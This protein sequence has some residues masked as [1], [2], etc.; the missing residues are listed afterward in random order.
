MKNANRRRGYAFLELSALAS[1]GLTF[2]LVTMFAFCFFVGISSV[3]V[4][5]GTFTCAVFYVANYRRINRL[6][7]EITQKKEVS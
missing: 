6:T 3:A 1:L 4:L 2:E 7:D 5:V